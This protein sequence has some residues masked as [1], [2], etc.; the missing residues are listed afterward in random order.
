MCGL[1]SIG[2]PLWREDGSAIC[3]VITQWSE[4]IR[5]R[6]HTLLPL[7]RLP[8]PGG[9]GSRIYIPQEQNSPVIPRG[10]GFPL[11]RLLRLAGLRR[12][13]SNPS[14]TWRARFP[15]LCPPGTGW[16]SYTPGHWVYSKQRECQTLANQES[17]ALWRQ[18][19][20]WLTDI[21]IFTAVMH[22]E[23]NGVGNYFR[24]LNHQVLV[25][26]MKSFKTHIIISVMYTEDSRFM[27]RP[28]LN[29]TERLSK[30][31]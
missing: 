11:R 20:F 19:L 6:N 30:V 4:S 29:R 23:G 25:Q 15:Y 3:S 22:N 31:F 8:Q 28:F 10:T 18:S 5:T 24:F 1:V 16:P 27:G 14:P 17:N 12:R 7:L 21:Q 26:K 9:S 13:Y 2:R